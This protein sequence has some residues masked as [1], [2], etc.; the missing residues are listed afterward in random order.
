MSNSDNHS[1]SI[2][3]SNIHCFK[4]HWLLLG[5][6][7]GLSACC[8]PS[9]TTNPTASGAS[10]TLEI[11]FSAAPNSSRPL[12]LPQ[13]GK[14]LDW[15]F[16]GASKHG[17]AERVVVI[18]P[19]QKEV[20]QRFPVVIALHGRGEA[21]RG[22]EAGAYGWVR[23]YHLLQTQKVLS[24]GL[25]TT[26][27]MQSLADPLR[28]QSFNDSLKKQSYQGLIVVCPH[29]PDILAGKR[30][31][32]D[33]TS[34]G[35]WLTETLLPRVQKETPA[36]QAVGIDGVSLGGRVS[37]L[38]GA[39][40]PQTFQSVGGLQPAIQVAEGTELAQRFEHYAQEQPH[41]H[42]RLLTSSKDYF[43]EPVK[44]L[45]RKLRKRQVEHELV[46]IPGPHDYS[47]NQGPGGFEMLMWH[48]RV[49]RNQVSLGSFP[50][51][52]TGEDLGPRFGQNALDVVFRA[53]IASQNNY[54]FKNRPTYRSF[55]ARTKGW[56]TKP[57]NHSTN[58]VPLHDAL[59]L[60]LVHF[61]SLSAKGFRYL[62]RGFW[63]PTPSI[64]C[65]NKNCRPAMTQHRCSNKHE[66]MFV[67]NVLH[68]LANVSWKLH[69]RKN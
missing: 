38:V 50:K 44:T 48:D 6:L 9:N 58:T 4:T 68:A 14:L 39:K 19:Q 66:N 17:G 64:R 3:F 51:S 21:T 43:L 42:I 31:L 16:K 24:L 23:D 69:F 5:M 15:E 63:I 30:T 22:P 25:I 52:K 59:G 37:L 46:I 41:G 53:A 57:F 36:S 35:K 67:W 47:F 13:S 65:A 33:A 49:L 18:V 32:N 40:Y 54:Q 45:S 29:T 20:G 61:G 7:F 1:L 28:L 62:P 11:Q 12:P 8:S 26:D 60:K 55:F 27:D 56:P 2:I 10:S 34:F